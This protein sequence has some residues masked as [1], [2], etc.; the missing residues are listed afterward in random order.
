MF[1]TSL[2]YDIIK[3]ASSPIP[4]RALNGGLYTGEPFAKDAEYRNFPSE[5][6]SAT[7][8]HVNLRSANPPFLALYHMQV[9]YRPGNNTDPEIPDTGNKTFKAEYTPYTLPCINKCDKYNDFVVA[10]YDC[11]MIWA[12]R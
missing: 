10:P 1:R 11:K 2:G 6:T 7:Q 9:G 4:E 3:D 8:N 12:T 5:P